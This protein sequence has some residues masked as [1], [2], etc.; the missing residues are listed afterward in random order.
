MKTLMILTAALTASIASAVTYPIVDTGQTTAFGTDKGQ[1]A[2]YFANAPSYTDNGNGTVTDNVTGLM[3]T[4]DPGAKMTFNKAVAGASK[5]K[6]GGYTD[7]RLPTIKEL[8]SLIQLNGT[9][10]DPMSTDTSGLK[11]FIDDSVFKFTYGKEEDGD[12]IIDSQFATSTKYVSTTMRGAETMFGVNFADGRI[13]G[14]GIEDPRGRGAKTFYVLYVRGN[15]DY[16]KNK[17]KDNGDETVTDKATGLTWMQADSGKGMDWPTALEYAEDM[18]FAGHSDWRLPNAKE[19]QSIIDYTRSPDTTGSAAIDPMFDAT[20]IINEGGK[21]D[22]AHYW[23]SSSHLSTR[24]SDTAVYFA[25]GRSL[26]FMKD[27]RT[28]EY[29][30]MDVHGAG[31]QRS[32]PKVGDAAKFPHGRGPQ[33]DVIRIENMV[34]LVRGGGVEK[35]EQDSAIENPPAQVRRGRPAGNQQPDRPRGG[36]QAA[37]GSQGSRPRDKVRSRDTEFNEKF[38]EGSTWADSLQLYNADRELVAA[39]SI[40]DAE[41]T[42]VVGGCLTCPEYRNSYPEIEAVAA[43][44]RDK[45]VQFYFLYQ[46]LTHPENWGFVQPTSIQERFAQVEYAKELLQTS[47]PWLTDTMDNEMK[48]SFAMAPNSQFVFDRDGRIVH[49]DSWGRGSSLRE[50]LEKL[51]GPSDRI[52]TVADLNLPQF[53]RKTSSAN[54]LLEPLRLDGVAVPLRVTAGGEEAN[55]K[56]IKSRDYGESNRYAKLRP[57]A[58]QQLIQTGTGQLYLGFRQDPVLGGAWNNL[59][60]P[61][62]Y[63]VTANGATVTP[64]MA[65]SPELSVESDTEPRE[66]LVDV[67]NWKAGTPIKVEIQYFACNKEKGWCEAVEQEFTVWLEEDATAGKVA[68]RS[69]FPGGSGQ[70]GRGGQ[71]QRQGGQNQRRGQ[72]PGG[73][74]MERGDRNGDGKVAKDEF[75]GPAEHFG[76]LDK[77]GDGFITEDEAPTGPPPGRR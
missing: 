46:S 19:L 48:Q 21:K 63:R 10:P 38:P 4:Q 29:T 13:K 30:L 40:F 61:P 6:V 17:F 28:G 49:R 59:A 67:K 62:K 34:R 20:E 72:N 18:E 68:G 33:G 75:R 1:D 70:G 44:Y 45:G 58:D 23:T 22:Y 73:S 27:R 36:G 42:V 54:G 7:W 14:Y 55:A 50:S 31:S 43:D 57:E 35:M 24:G 41:Y 39:N 51:V 16:G 65:E 56:D 77:N 3:W 76:H 5:C 64:A 26:G 2:H 12:R 53:G 9:D 11:P 15:P 66:F 25:F 37:R 69:H 60:T 71:S 32:D 47:I 52:T 8:Y 74:F